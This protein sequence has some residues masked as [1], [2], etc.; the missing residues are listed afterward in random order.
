MITGVKQRCPL[1]QCFV[2]ADRDTAGL[3]RLLR[4]LL[5]VPLSGCKYDPPC[6]C[7]TGLGFVPRYEIIVL[8]HSARMEAAKYRGI[9]RL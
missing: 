2:I 5:P 1:C 4:D 8:G 6:S 3:R 7:H 9:I